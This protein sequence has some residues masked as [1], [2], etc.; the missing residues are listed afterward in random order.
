[1]PANNSH[2]C[3]NCR[4]KYNARHYCFIEA[5]P[6]AAMLKNWPACRCPYCTSGGRY[7]VQPVEFAI[8]RGKILRNPRRPPHS[9]LYIGR[10]GSGKVSRM[11]WV[12]D[13]CRTFD[14]FDCRGAHALSVAR[15]V[16]QAVRTRSTIGSVGVLSASAL[17]QA[18]LAREEQIRNQQA[19]LEA[20]RTE[21]VRTTPNTVPTDYYEAWPPRRRS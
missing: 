7:H 14:G 9:M 3:N 1:M 13:A 12:C 20:L 15:P 6:E 21:F 2:T 10:N 17:S 18:M 16:V 4:V 8:S 11:A 5:G 19:A